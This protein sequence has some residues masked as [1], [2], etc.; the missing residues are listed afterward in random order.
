MGT[1]LLRFIQNSIRAQGVRTPRRSPLWTY[2]L[3]LHA[4][5]FLPVL[6]LLGCA[7]GGGQARPDPLPSTSPSITSQPTN[8]VIKVGQSAP[9]AVGATG[10][11][12]LAYQWQRNG[13]NV[14]GAISASYTTPPARA[15]DDGERFSVVVTNSIGST[16]S[17]SAILTVLIPPSITTQPANQTVNMGQAATFTVM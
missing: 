13:A 4:L 10:T 16:T 14:S 6:I 3:L 15:S 8:Q 9:F 5:S 1:H 11:A 2:L 12:P 17:A 7:G